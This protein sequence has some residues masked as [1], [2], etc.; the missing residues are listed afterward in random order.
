[1]ATE[2]PP[3]T[4]TPGSFHF[5]QHAVGSQGFHSLRGRLIFRALPT[6]RWLLL[7]RGNLLPS[8]LSCIIKIQQSSIISKYYS[9]NIWKPTQLFFRKIIDFAFLNIKKFQPNFYDY[10]KLTR[11]IFPK[12]QNCEVLTADTWHLLYAR[13]N[14]QLLTAWGVFPPAE[15]TCTYSYCPLAHKLHRENSKTK[16]ERFVCVFVG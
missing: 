3:H 1:M 10:K 14:S 4:H 16:A 8:P 9:S 2:P 13:T 5:P 15:P 11:D 6:K 7:C 12:F